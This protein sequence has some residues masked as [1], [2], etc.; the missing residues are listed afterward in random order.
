[1]KG[2][3]MSLKGD[4]VKEYLTK[5]PDTPTRTLANL[6]YKE[7]VS[8]F[9]NVEGARRTLRYYR[10]QSG[11]KDREDLINTSFVKTGTTNPFGEL[12]DGLTEYV[13]WKPVPLAGE[14]ILAL[15][16]IH[17]PYHDKTALMCALEYGIKK[18]IDTVLILGDLI[19][20]YTVSFWATNPKHRNF[21]NEVQTT[22]SIL[23]VIRKY[24]PNAQIVYK[25]GNHEERY[26]RYMRVKAPELL[27][28]EVFEFGNIIDA[29]NYEIDLIGEKRILKVGYLNCI[30]GHEF[31]KGVTNPVNPAR[32]LFLRGKEIA[33][34]AHYHQSSQHT[35]K[36]L[37]DAII[38]CWSIGCLCDLHPEYMPINKWNHGFAFI[39]NSDSFKFE[40]LKIIN[41]KVM[42]A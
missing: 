42:P 26:E 40:N 23:E 34:C 2:M 36:T 27:G 9:T 19:D 38:S 8:T 33:C 4:I 11:A 28:F 30:H 32:G 13:N 5:Y 25:L 7:N 31:W 37:L 22:K 24:F 3:G 6:I 20:F 18:D 41:G 15:G 14:R 16:D 17:S 29:K 35:E 12:P 1:M 10:G 39:E 21:K